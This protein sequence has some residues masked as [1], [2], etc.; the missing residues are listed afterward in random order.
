MSQPFF[1]SPWR[2]QVNSSDGGRSEQGGL[3][4]RPPSAV[5][6]VYTVVAA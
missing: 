1:F 6:F 4:F 5:T 3:G 2:M